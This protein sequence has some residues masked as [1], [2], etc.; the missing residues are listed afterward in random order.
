[1]CRSERSESDVAA[2]E[3]EGRGQDQEDDGGREGEKDPRER[4]GAR[5][6]GGQNRSGLSFPDTPAPAPAPEER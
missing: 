2:P 5:L 4:Q 1:M 3:E 6:R